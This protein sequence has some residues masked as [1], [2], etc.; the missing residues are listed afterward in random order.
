LQRRDIG[1]SVKFGQS[2]R[3]NGLPVATL[4]KYDCFCSSVPK[5]VIAPEPSPCIA[6]AK[7]AILNGAPA[8]ANHTDCPGIDRV[9]KSAIRFAADHM[10]Q[11]I[12]FAKLA[13][14]LATYVVD[15]V[16]V[17]GGQLGARPAI[18]FVASAL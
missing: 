9:G 17:F 16:V 12:T 18:E 5:S 11:P 1:A 13:D 4:G 2:E 3:G 8:F 10:I 14:E 15:I 6:K 7:S